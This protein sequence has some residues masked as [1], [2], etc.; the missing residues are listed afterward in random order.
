MET[1][2][3]TPKLKIVV[4]SKERQQNYNS[5]LNN[6]RLEVVTEYKYLGVLFL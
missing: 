5:I 3:Y 4:F 1:Y 6:V 2:F